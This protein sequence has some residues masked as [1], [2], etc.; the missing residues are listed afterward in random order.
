MS[1]VVI[2][3]PFAE[4]FPAAP[5]AASRTNSDSAVSTFSHS[6]IAARR[7][8]VAV[9]LLRVQF[10]RVDSSG[11]ALSVSAVSCFSQF[12]EF[13]KQSANMLTPHLAVGKLG[14]HVL[15]PNSVPIKVR[16]L[17]I[18]PCQLVSDLGRFVVTP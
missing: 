14:F 1:R 11:L 15:S 7:T 2:A 3:A 4:R 13:F 17:D 5:H 10:G 9:A 12:V 18:Q 8:Y 6:K 16:L